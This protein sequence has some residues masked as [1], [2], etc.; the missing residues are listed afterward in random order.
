MATV[1]LFT[2]RTIFRTNHNL[3]EIERFRIRKKIWV[4]LILSLCYLAIAAL[5]IMKGWL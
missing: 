1:P 4:K 3:A 5:I 2:I